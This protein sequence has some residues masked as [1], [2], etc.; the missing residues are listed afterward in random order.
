MLYKTNHHPN[1]NVY[2]NR[3]PIKMLLKLSLTITPI[4]TYLRNIYIKFIK[5]KNHHRYIRI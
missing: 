4:K 5:I 1:Q 3:A 2:K